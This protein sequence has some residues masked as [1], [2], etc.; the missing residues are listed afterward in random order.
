MEGEDGGEEPTRSIV[1]V[2]DEGRLEHTRHHIRRADGWHSFWR[3]ETGKS[4]EG[5][6]DSHSRSTAFP[7]FY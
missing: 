7:R 4:L 5:I 2:A 6:E 1:G 3:M